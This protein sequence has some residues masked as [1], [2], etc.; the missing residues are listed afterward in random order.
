MLRNF[1][2]IPK[3]LSEELLFRQILI[4]KQYRI[5]NILKKKEIIKKK[6][7]LL[8]KVKEKNEV[9]FIQIHN[10]DQAF[11]TEQ[12]RVKLYK[13]LVNL[14]QLEKSK[15][16]MAIKQKLITTAKINKSHIQK[17]IIRWISQ[18]LTAK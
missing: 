14:T 5:K 9:A 3:T 11:A 1:F 13:K 2:K 15:Y 4:R 7:G 17:G 10:I 6:I 16:V 12:T 18:E 8:K